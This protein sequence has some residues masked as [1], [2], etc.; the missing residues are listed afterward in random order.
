MEHLTDK[1]I[2]VADEWVKHLAERSKERDEETR[3][4]VYTFADEGFCRIWD[5][6]V[7]RLPSVKQFY[8]PY[9]WTA[10]IDTVV[11]SLDDA[12]LISEKYG[13]HDFLFYAITD[14]AENRSKGKGKGPMYGRIARSELI[15]QFKERLRAL[16]SNRSLGLL[17]PNDTG[18]REAVEFGFPQ[19]NIGLWDATSEDGLEKAM[20]MLKTSTDTY[21]TTRETK[22][23]GSTS[24]FVGENVDANSIKNAKLVPLPVDDRRFVLVTKSRST[25]SLFFEKA[26][27]AVTKKRLVPDKAWHVEISD[28]VNAAHPP[29]RVGMAFYELI[30]SEKVAADKRIAVV[31]NNTKQVYVGPG[32][33]QLLGL[34]NGECRVKPTLNPDYKIFVESTSLNRHLRLGTELLLLTK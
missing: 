21:L 4:S 22:G 11:L 12:D 28:F 10:L 16:A 2:Q 5:T 18:Y 23:R 34:P 25:E 8:Q 30:K 19:G 6:D 15:R 9:G 24:L 3:I 1:V 26:I 17:V 31:D 27:N 7:L 20:T 14:G 33:R 13:K 29:Y 32:A